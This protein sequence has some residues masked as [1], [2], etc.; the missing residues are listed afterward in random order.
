M[1][2][3]HFRKLFKRSPANPILSASNWPY[4]ANPAQER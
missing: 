1:T 4:P 3:P 2:N